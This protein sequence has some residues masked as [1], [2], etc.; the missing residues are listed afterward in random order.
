MHTGCCPRVTDQESLSLVLTPQSSSLHD[1]T[2]AS[3]LMHSLLLHSAWLGPL[4]ARMGLVPWKAQGL[5]EFLLPKSLAG[6]QGGQKSLGLRA[7]GCWLSCSCQPL[8]KSLQ[9]DWENVPLPA[10]PAP[11]HLGTGR[12]L[13]GQTN[14]PLEPRQLGSLEAG[15]CRVNR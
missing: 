7:L 12:P 10:W 1:E 2:G 6:V 5:A 15:V 11:S 8:K 13:Q 9:R 4:G 3:G 14:P